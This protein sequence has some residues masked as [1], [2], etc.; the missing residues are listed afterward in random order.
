MENEI[1]KY[2][3]DIYNESTTLPENFGEAIIRKEDCL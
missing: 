3:D 1:R 2:L